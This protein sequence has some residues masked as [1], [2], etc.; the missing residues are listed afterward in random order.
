MGL[1]YAVTPQTTFYYL[2]QNVPTIFTHLAARALVVQCQKL[3]I[4]VHCLFP[5]NPHIYKHTNHP[6]SQQSLFSTQIK[7]FAR[8]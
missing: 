6:H 8:R 3:N 4:G 2:S 1:I 7:E 5:V